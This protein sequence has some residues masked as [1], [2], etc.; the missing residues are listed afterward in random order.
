MR[1]LLFVKD[2]L[3]LGKDQQKDEWISAQAIHLMET[4][5]P[6]Y[7]NETPVVDI[8]RWKGLDFASS[9]Y[10]TLPNLSQSFF[11]NLLRQCSATIS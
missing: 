7:F 3:P 5:N 4:F 8:I 2:E 6:N 11:S 10:V 1:F 9:M